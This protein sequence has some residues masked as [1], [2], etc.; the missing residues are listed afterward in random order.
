M[1]NWPLRQLVYSGGRTFSSLSTRFSVNFH[2]AVGN[3]RHYSS[4]IGSEAPGEQLSD[5][6]DGFSG[7]DTDGNT[8]AGAYVE[9]IVRANRHC[10]WTTEQGT[11]TPQMKT[12]L[13]RRKG[14]WK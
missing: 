10:V 4:R 8:R 12:F 3:Y 6:P 11:Y 9:Q 5:S 7:R 1:T 14:F 2:P 13:A